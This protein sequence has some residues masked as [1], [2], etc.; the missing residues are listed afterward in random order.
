M[1]ISK[2]PNPERRFGYN[3]DKAVPLEEGIV[4]GAAHG[5][6]YIDFQ[7]DMPPNDLASFDRARVGRVRDL[8]ERHAVQLGVHP[9][10]AINNAEYVPILSE[11]VDE[12]INANFD[13]AVRLGCGWFVG[14][15]GYHF[16]DIGLRR[17]VAIDRLKRLVDRAEQTDVAI[18]FENHNLEPERAEMH[19]LPHDVEETQWF[20]DAIQSDH[21]KW[22][23][24]VAHGHLVPEGWAGFLDAFGVENIGQVRLNDN[25]GDYE[26]HLV[27]GEGT[28]DF[29]ALFKRLNAMG[30][31][32]W[33]S[34]GFGDDA[35]KIRVKKEFERTGRRE[36]GD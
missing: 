3:L 10:S 28:I 14:H 18:Y 13:L 22:A 36:K 32:G 19:Y 26:V 5:F 34:L 15:G 16:G 27:P 23:F 29:D 9:S 31:A 11:A 6:Y 20:F 8:C 30:Y 2:A 33:F 17:E 4:W 1:K 24:N 7:A 12:Y 21:F 35:D 25:D